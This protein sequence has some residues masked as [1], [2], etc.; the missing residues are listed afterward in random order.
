MVPMEIKRTSSLT[1]C[2]FAVG[3][4]VIL[5]LAA[6]SQVAHASETGDSFRRARDVT[7]DVLLARP[8]GFV[9][10]VVSVVMFPITYPAGL[11]VG[12]SDLASRVCIQEPADR[13]FKRP[14]GEL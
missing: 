12:D 11:I 4:A 1:R 2:C 3:L 9:Q 10:L 13:V 14:L 6:S 8:F 7:A 5:S